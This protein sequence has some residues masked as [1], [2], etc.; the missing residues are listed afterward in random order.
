MNLSAYA[1]KTGSL[2]ASVG[3]PWV[4][5]QR[6]GCFLDCRGPLRI[7]ATSQWGFCVRVLTESH[8]IHAGP[9]PV[10]AVQPYGV[11]VEADT[12]IG[13][14]SLL[15]GCVIGAGSI[16]AAGAVVRGQT[17][18]PGVMVAGDPARVIARWDGER[19]AYLPGEATGY[20]RMLA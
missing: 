1:G 10:G 16:V 14:W 5:F 7:H 11:T 13:S 2:P 8:D 19:W 18:A 12:W 9:G 17:V 15:A 4:Y 6:R 3:R 20:E